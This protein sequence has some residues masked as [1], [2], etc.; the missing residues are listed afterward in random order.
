MAMIPETAERVEQNTAPPI[1]REVQ[2]EIADSVR[3]HSTHPERICSRLGG[4]RSGMGYRT[5]A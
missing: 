4:T 3:W 2:V 1:N 5:D